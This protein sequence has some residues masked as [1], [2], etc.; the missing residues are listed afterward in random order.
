MR[1]P[2]L[3]SNDIIL[4]ASRHNFIVIR[5]FYVLVSTRNVRSWRTQSSPL[6]F[7]RR[8]NEPVPIKGT[9]DIF[10]VPLG[11]A[12]VGR[13]QFARAILACARLSSSRHFGL[14]D[15]GGGDYIFKVQPCTCS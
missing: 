7:W 1:E 5:I 4:R 2:I 14:S 8:C 15:C 9:V 13:V 11:T 3:D 12:V 6:P 10:N